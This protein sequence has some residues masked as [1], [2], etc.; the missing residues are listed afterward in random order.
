MRRVKATDATEKVG[1]EASELCDTR[2]NITTKEKH[3]TFMLKDVCRKEEMSQSSPRVL[4]DSMQT[5]PPIW[6]VN[7]VNNGFIKKW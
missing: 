3:H 2:E 6:R 4:D 5:H 1:G 7:L